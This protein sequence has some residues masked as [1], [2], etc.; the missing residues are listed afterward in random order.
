MKNKLLDQIIVDLVAEHQG[1]E[2]FFDHLDE[3]IRKDES[4]MEKLLDTYL[5]SYSDSFLNIIVS[6]SFG[7]MF[8]NFL[9]NKN[10]QQHIKCITVNG[11]L[12]HGD[13][14]D[15]ISYMSIKGRSFVF[16]DDSFYKGRTRDAVKKALEANG[17]TLSH[18]F[19][20]YD[21][22]KTKDET[23]TSLYRFFED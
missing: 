6:G 21:G 10:I 9:Q 16:F 2:V 18:T 5:N 1:G 20:V 17:A 19:V 4:I 3:V 15:D 23:V 22:S 14:V 7:R 12:R 11:S 13:P 8:S